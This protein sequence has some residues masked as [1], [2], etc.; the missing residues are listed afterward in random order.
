MDVVVYDEQDRRYVPALLVLL[1]VAGAAVLAAAVALL[2]LRSPA[3]ASSARSPA[4]PGG[5]T[6]PSASAS[7]TLG[8]SDPQAATTDGTCA[9]AL[10]DA[11]RALDRAGDLDRELAAHT[12][13][14]DDL[15]AKRTD[16]AGVLDRSLPVL[17]EAATD[18]LRFAEELKAYRAARKTCGS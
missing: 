12:E 10:A 16:A 17:T 6:A 13:V 2:V 14:L 18:R 1:L 7:P 9:Q 15:L 4:S 8:Q 3:G 11:D 5:V